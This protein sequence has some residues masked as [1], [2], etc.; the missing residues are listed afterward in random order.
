MLAFA[1]NR[2]AVAIAVGLQAMELPLLLVWLVVTGLRLI[3][4]QG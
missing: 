2:D 3:R 4:G 1:Q